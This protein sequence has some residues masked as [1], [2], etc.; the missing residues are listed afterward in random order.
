MKQ[1]LVAGA[2]PGADERAEETEHKRRE[3]GSR[4]PGGILRHFV[5]QR[6]FPSFDFAA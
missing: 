5:S 2:E 3:Q 1:A 4:G 6:T